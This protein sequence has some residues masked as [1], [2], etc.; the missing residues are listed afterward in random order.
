[1]NMERVSACTYPLREKSAAEAFQVIAAAGIHK[2]DLW[3][4]M[5]HFSADAAE[6]DPAALQAAAASCGVRIANLGTYPGAGFSSESTAE[7][8]AALQD[9]RRTI[10]CATALGV[11]SIRIRP[12]DKDDPSLIGRM[13]PWFKRSAAFAAQH[14]VYL[15][16]EN[17][18]GSIAGRLD[19]CADLC[20]QVDSPFFGVL[21]EPC[22]LMLG[23]VD[24]KE[25]FECFKDHIVHLHVKDCAEVNG[26][27]VSVHLGEGMIDY[28]W[29]LEKLAGIGYA[30]DYALEYELCEIEPIETGLPRWVKVFQQLPG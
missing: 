20:A 7:Q 25:A 19:A 17:H 12:G 30:G 21:F 14:G 27:R 1:M 10:E 13:V 9:M 11:R 23:G 3:G 26:K 24:Y 6:C 28:G 8:E 5:P 2:A 15:G 16:M 29:V 18:Q 22:N 4:R